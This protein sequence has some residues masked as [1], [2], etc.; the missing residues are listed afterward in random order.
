MYHLAYLHD[1]QL[2]KVYQQIAKNVTAKNKVENHSDRV[3]AT[4][5]YDDLVALDEDRVAAIQWT[6]GADFHGSR[7]PS[8]GRVLTEHSPN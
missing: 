7:Q 8:R 5:T 4:F 1:F 6:G 2:D 3:A